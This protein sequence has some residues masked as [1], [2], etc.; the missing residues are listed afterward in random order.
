MA[1]EYSLGLGDGDLQE[2]CSGPGHL[3]SAEWTVRKWVFSLKLARGVSGWLLPDW[4][5]VL[6]LAVLKW[7]TFEP[8]K[9]SIPETPHVEDSLLVSLHVSAP[10]VRAACAGLQGT[11]FGNVG[12]RCGI[13]PRGRPFA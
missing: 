1:T 7:Q 8:F 6:V 11:L 3:L 10:R 12:D 13:I 4:S 5:S 9:F 2:A